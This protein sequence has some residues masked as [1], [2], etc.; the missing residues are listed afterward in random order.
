MIEVEVNPSGV[1]SDYL[2]GLQTC[3]PGWGD[4]RTYHWAF[5]REVGAPRADLIVLRKDGELIAGSAVTYRQV[6]LPR[7]GTVLSGIMTGSWTLPHGRGQG[8]FR[9]MIEESL[10]I[11]AGKGAALLLAFVT[12]HNASCSGLQKTGATLFPTSYVSSTAETPRPSARSVAARL[13]DGEALAAALFDAAAK[14]A[15]SARFAYPS[16]EAWGSQLLRRP[17]PV[18]VLGFGA[19]SWAVVEQHGDT[20]RV[21]LVV[22]ERGE[23]GVRETIEALLQRAIDRGRRLFLFSTSASV[24]ALCERLGMAQTPGYLTVLV[25]DIV[26]LGEALRAPLPAPPSALRIDQPG[27]PWFIGPWDVQSGERM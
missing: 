7:S 9:R 12:R 19:G 10:S 25:A 1:D 15:G 6:A 21:Q 24:R 20:D 18:E 23:D 13:E 26:R 2:R 27:S 11:C 22:A 3:F 4:Q 14:R 17:S 16:V 5:D 8:C